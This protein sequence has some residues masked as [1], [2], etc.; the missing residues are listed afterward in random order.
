MIEKADMERVW[1]EVAS[2]FAAKEENAV[3]HW[4]GKNELDADVVIEFMSEHL[5]Q[6]LLGA[7]KL[8]MDEGGGSEEFSSSLIAIACAV[9]MMGWELHTQ[10]GKP[11]THIA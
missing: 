5:A 4:T 7:M 10:L 9:F 1:A 6:M 2:A 3:D 11:S 8:A